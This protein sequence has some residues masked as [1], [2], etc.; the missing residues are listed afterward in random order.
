MRRS[1]FNQ[2][3]LRQGFIYPKLSWNVLIKTLLITKNVKVKT[4]IKREVPSIKKKADYEGPAIQPRDG[5]QNKLARYVS[6]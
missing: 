1:I 4:F 2:V 6:T 3:I 5:S